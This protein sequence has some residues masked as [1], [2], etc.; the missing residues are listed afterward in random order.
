M[1]FRPPA[2]LVLPLLLAMALL[3]A[4]AQG[5]GAEPENGGAG[6]DPRG[7]MELADPPANREAIAGPPESAVRPGLQVLLDDSL[8]LV[9]G[10]RVGLVTNHTGVDTEGVSSID[11]LSGH[12]EVELVAL[13][14]PEHG[15]RGTAEAGE[16]VDHSRD[17]ATGLP[18]HSLYGETRKPTPAML[19][20]VEILLF[21]IL[22]I[23]TRYYTYI[24]TMGLAMEAAGE[25]G[26]PFV[27]LDRPNVI[28]GR[29]VQGNVL[30]PSFSSFVGMYPLPIRHGMTPGELA[31]LYRDAFGI[32]AELHVVPAAGWRREMLFSDTGLPWRPPSPN[33]PSEESALHYPGTCLF[34]GTNLS[35]GRGTDRAFQQIGAPWLDADELVRRM[36]ARSQPGVRFEAVRFTPVNPGDGKFP[37]Q[38]VEGVRLHVTDPSRYDP[39]EAGVA[40]LVEARRMSGERWRWN[41]SHFD[42]LAGTDALR[43][44]I[45][46]GLEVEALREGWREELSAFLPLREEALLY[47]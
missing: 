9:R 40:L 19:E 25:A 15:I 24:Y 11:R 46:A 43:L 26:I 34:E 12:R 27:V 28:G 4:C 39:T 33:M 32:R 38:E 41:A 47:R 5:N 35:V 3:P 36:Q 29:L 13:F 44:G 6:G 45:E 2:P 31:R 14:S 23:G 37:G 21:D 16:L 7:N 8:H 20:G 17:E 22:D 18:V 42:R 1:P 10:R 30:D